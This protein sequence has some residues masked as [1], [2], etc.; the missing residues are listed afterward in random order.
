MA[1]PGEVN[2]LVVTYDAGAYVFTDTGATIRPGPCA[3]VTPNQVRCTGI[4]PGFG[5]LGAML[6]DGNDELSIAAPGP[7]LGVEGG[8]GNDSVDAR[9][10]TTGEPVALAGGAGDDTLLGGPGGAFLYGNDG[11][12]TLRGGG[13]T[14]VVEGGAGPDSID[15]GLGADTVTYRGSAPVTVDLGDPGPDGAAGENDTLAGVENVTVVG[16]G[17]DVLVGDEGPNV[18]VAGGGMNLVDGRGGAD[19]INVGDRRD[20]VLGGDGDDVIDANGTFLRGRTQPIACGAGADLVRAPGSSDIARARLRARGVPR[21]PPELAAGGARYAPW[22]RRVP[23]ARGVPARLPLLRSSRPSQWPHAARPGLPARDGR[24]AALPRA[25]HSRAAA[26]SS[27]PAGPRACRC[28][29]GATAAARPAGAWAAARRA[30][31]ASAASRRSWTPV[32][33]HP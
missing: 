18:L 8:D 4:A 29:C 14:D 19:R 31:T 30:R 9:A 26:R 23:L 3:A 11:P 2:R 27:A 22:H 6:G 17:N 28:R 13:G 20:R 25:A 33:R 15:T 7:G 1:D 10:L 12:D 24:D 16:S 21:L 32:R 5:Y